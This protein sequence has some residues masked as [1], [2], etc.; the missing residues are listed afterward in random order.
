[1]EEP[2][3]SYKDETIMLSDAG[4]ITSNA[5]MFQTG[6]PIPE[7]SRYTLTILTICICISYFLV[8]KR[9]KVKEE[10]N[11]IKNNKI[12]NQLNYEKRTLQ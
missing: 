6:V 3:L 2:G 5:Y 12:N 8:S 7:F 10:T 11:F 4:T 1:V 9:T